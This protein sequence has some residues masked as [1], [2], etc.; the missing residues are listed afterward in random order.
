MLA[1][2]MPRQPAATRRRV[3]RAGLG[4]SST[5]P[6]PSARFQMLKILNLSTYRLLVCWRRQLVVS[7]RFTFAREMC[8]SSHKGSWQTV[9]CGR[10]EDETRRERIV[11][12]PQLARL[13]SEAY[14][15]RTEG[16]SAGALVQIES[17]ASHPCSPSVS[18]TAAFSA[19]APLDRRRIIRQR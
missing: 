15:S 6:A 11:L 3:G 2:D 10:E 1:V 16:H 9:R 7:T 8:L 18:A 4:T 19:L 5:T 14:Y 17:I 12:S 13:A